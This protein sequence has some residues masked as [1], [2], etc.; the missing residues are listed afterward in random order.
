MVK[1]Y[2][3][4]GS[5]S[6]YASAYAS[7]SFGPSIGFLAGWALLLDYV[8]LPLVNYLVIGI[9]LNILFRRFRPGY[10]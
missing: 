9:Y 2:P 7:K 6:A 10:S 8:L 5:A 4:A 1:G 3:V